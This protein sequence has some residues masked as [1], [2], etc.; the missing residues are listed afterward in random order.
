MSEEAGS[1]CSR[2]S[3]PE[4]PSSGSGQQLPPDE[5]SVTMLDVLQEEEEL[6]EDA[7]AVLGNT[8]DKHC[9]YSQVCNALV[10]WVV[11]R[12]RQL[13]YLIIMINYG[14]STYMKLDHIISPFF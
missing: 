4:E 2:S 8:D 5:D 9:S 3:S 13:Y 14:T 6:D 7:D 11:G 10:F 12:C 1:S